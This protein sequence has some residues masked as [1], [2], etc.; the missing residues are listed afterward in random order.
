MVSPAVAVTVPVTNVVELS[1]FP[2]AQVERVPDHIRI[3]NSDFTSFAR[4]LRDRRAVGLGEANHGTADFYTYRGELSLELARTGAPVARRVHVLGIDAQRLEPPV[5][6][7]LARRAELAISEGEAELLAKVAP[8]HGKQFSQL[9]SKDKAAL[10]EALERLGNPS[11]PPD[12]GSMV[13]RASIAARSI[14]SSSVIWP[15]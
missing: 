14:R 10:T 12:L 15:R 1:A 2:A 9:D 8:G 13:T 3:K 4:A 5:Q 6:W 7:L 11:G